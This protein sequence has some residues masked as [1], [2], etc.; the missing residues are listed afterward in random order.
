MKKKIKSLKEIGRSHFSKMPQE[1]VQDI[2]PMMAIDLF[3]AEKRLKRYKMVTTVMAVL[4][5]IDII[6]FLIRTF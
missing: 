2:L 5:V 4:L 6:G 1:I 3:Y